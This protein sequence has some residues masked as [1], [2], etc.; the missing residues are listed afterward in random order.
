MCPD[1]GT[2]LSPSNIA[3]ICMRMCVCV[4]CVRVCVL[5]EFV[6]MCMRHLVFEFYSLSICEH[7]NLHLSSFPLCGL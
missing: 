2:L 7:S 4:C 1:A 6:Q 5:I 3:I